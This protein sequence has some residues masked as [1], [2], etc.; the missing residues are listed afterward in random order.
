M[1]KWF[2][3][4]ILVSTTAHA[5]EAVVTVLEAPILAEKSRYSQ[6]VQYLRKGDVIKIHPSVANETKYDDLAPSKKKLEEIHKKLSATP[7]W[8]EDEVFKGDES[9]NAHI[10]DEFIPLVT[11]GGHIGYVLSEHIQ[12]F[13]NDK[14]EFRHRVYDQKDLTDYRLEEPLPRGYPVV[15]NR[16]LRG[17]ITLGF[18]QPYDH[19]Y[20]YLQSIK[21]KGYVSPIDFNFTVMKNVRSDLHDRFYYGLNVGFR[22][23]K[24]QYVF[25]DNKRSSSEEV[26]KAGL[27]PVVSFDVHKGEKNRIALYGRANFYLLN[28]LT[29]KQQDV[30]GRS[31]SRRYQGFSVTPTIGFQYHRKSV[32]ED[33]DLILGT[34]VETELSSSYRAQNGAGYKNWWRH[35]GND[36]YKP[37]TSFNISGYIGLQSIY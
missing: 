24:N 10:E 11:R 12:V 3:L 37:G 15:T 34:G 5:L 32:L 26:Y 33:V 16:G 21:A 2:L 23:Y 4:F 7:E 30:D 18:M 27:G 1:K 8:K 28:L 14:R 25:S 19:S 35:D 31:D 6:V 20:P 29:I 22:N 17:Q 36:R 9:Q 13:F